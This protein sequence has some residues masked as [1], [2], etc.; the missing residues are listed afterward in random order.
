LPLIYGS[1]AGILGFAFAVLL[2]YLNRHPFLIPVY[3]DSRIF[4]FAVFMFLLLRELREVHYSGILYFWQGLIACFL[5][6]GVFAMMTSVLIVLFGF[7]IPAFVESYID[8][9]ILQI[10]SLPV[11]V[12][13]KIGK[14]V[15]ASNL[16]DLPSTNAFDLGTLYLGQSFMIGLFLNIIISVISRRTP[17]P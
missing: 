2:Y 16:K 11:D 3:L 13:E 12:I 7:A 6:V 4:L 1:I 15:V 10:R 14:D 9:T 5:F 8:L 17:K